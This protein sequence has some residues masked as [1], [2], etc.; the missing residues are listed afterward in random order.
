MR[1]LSILKA[2]IDFIWFV[3]CLPFLLFMLIITVIVFF[4][5]E[6]IE[7]FDSI[8]IDSSM[9]P[10]FI[11]LFMVCIDI[12]CGVAVYCFYLFRKT[13]TCFRRRKPFDDLVIDNYNKIGKLLFGLGIVCAVL[14]FCINLFFKNRFTINL[15]VTP[16]LLM[17]CLGLFFMVLSEA[18]KIAKTAK[19][20]NELTV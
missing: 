4:D 2:L 8:E 7:I 10:W 5:V 3:N 1:K 20:E 13:L 14:F 17:S 9:S 12:L 6:A 11:K 19:E 15:G 18:F 16:Y